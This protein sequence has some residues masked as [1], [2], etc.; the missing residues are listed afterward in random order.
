[1]KDLSD[2]YLNCNNLNEGAGM[3][4]GQQKN[5]MGNEYGRREKETG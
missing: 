2:I 5:M 1:L 3:T 4:K